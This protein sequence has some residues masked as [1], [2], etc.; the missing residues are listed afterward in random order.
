MDVSKELESI[1][2]HFDAVTTDQLLSDLVESGLGKIESCEANGYTL[3]PAEE[4]SI[5]DT[6]F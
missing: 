1:N 5:E 6:L 3:M 2:A 4:T